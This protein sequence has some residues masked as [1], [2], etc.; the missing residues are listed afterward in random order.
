MVYTEDR[1]LS[2]ALERSIIMVYTEDRLLSG[3]LER[4]I[5]MVYT[6]DRQ[7]SGGPREERCITRTYNPS[8]AAVDGDRRSQ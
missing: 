6:E 8:E 7:L 4:S 1:L 3:A 5:I 2:G